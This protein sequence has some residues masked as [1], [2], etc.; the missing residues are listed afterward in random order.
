M[1][2]YEF[3]QMTNRQSDR[4]YFIEF[5][6]INSRMFQKINHRNEHFTTKH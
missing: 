6:F 5:D 3:D 1:T 2:S 4:Y